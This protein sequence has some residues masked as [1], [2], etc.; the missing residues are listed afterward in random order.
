MPLILNGFSESQND[1]QLERALLNRAMR[2]SKP[3]P[4]AH[5][6][7]GLLTE[8]D[9]ASLFMVSR[10]CACARRPGACFGNKTVLKR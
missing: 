9:I 5:S 4:H 7:P 3:G 2:A 10:E 1:W 6:K 8:Y